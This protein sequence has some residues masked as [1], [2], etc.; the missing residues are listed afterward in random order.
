MI[1]IMKIGKYA[2]EH[3][4][5]ISVLGIE[6]ADCGFNTLSVASELTSGVVS[7]VKPLGT[8][9]LNDYFFFIFDYLYFFFL[10]LQRQ[11]R[12]ILDNPVQAME[13]NVF[14]F[15][16]PQLQFTYAGVPG[17][18]APH[19]AEVYLSLSLFL[20]T[21]IFKKYYYCRYS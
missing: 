9:L 14:A 1:I 2:M 19:K 7:I 17:S 5:T 13:T 21:I 20:L 11:M 18:G 10:E 3:G 12:M 4:T 16:H 6:G 8:F 15:I